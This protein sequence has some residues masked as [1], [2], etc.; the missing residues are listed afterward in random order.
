MVIWFYRDIYK[1]DNMLMEWHFFALF[2]MHSKCLALVHGG[3]AITVALRW[4]IENVTI[5]MRLQW[6]NDFLC[7]CIRACPLWPVIGVCKSCYRPTLE[8]DEITAYVAGHVW[9]HSYIH[10][11]MW[12]DLTV[13]AVLNRDIWMQIW[14]FFSVLS[15]MLMRFVWILERAILTINH[16]WWIWNGALA[17][18]PACVRW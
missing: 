15:W 10:F 16:K 1:S 18:A 11:Q 3:F 8:T 5:R 2:R 13:V 4:N 12:W 7:I 14:R 6:Q 17:R 9:Q